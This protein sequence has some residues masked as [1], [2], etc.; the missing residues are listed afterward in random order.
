[1]N[2]LAVHAREQLPLIRLEREAGHQ[3]SVVPLFLRVVIDR[4]LQQTILA[5]SKSRSLKPV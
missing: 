3:T 1:V 2:Q 5:R 4:Q